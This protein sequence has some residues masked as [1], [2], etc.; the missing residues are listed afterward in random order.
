MRTC[1][2]TTSAPGHVRD[3]VR[4]FDFDFIAQ[5][6]M[7][8]QLELVDSTYSNRYF[9]VYVGGVLITPTLFIAS[10]DTTAQ[11]VRFVSSK[12]NRS[13][14]IEDLGLWPIDTHAA[15][16]P[17]WINEEEADI[18]RTIRFVW[19]VDTDFSVAKG[20]ISLSENGDTQLTDWELSGLSR[21]SNILNKNNQPFTG[22]LY[23]RF[24]KLSTTYYLEIYAANENTYTSGN[25]VAYGTSTGNPGTITLAEVNS[26][27]VSGQVDY[28]WA[29]D[30]DDYLEVSWPESYQI[31]YSTSAMTF[32]RTPQDTVAFNGRSQFYYTTPTIAAG[33]YEAAVVPVINGVAQDTGITPTTGIVILDIPDAPTITG[34]S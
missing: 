17:S 5:N 27:G 23:Y 19:E 33:T 28:N 16:Y 12:A 20:N 14:A 7:R 13:I 34:V 9:G 15:N 24:Y 8:V 21:W 26:S 25:M 32:P 6:S 11:A 29:A 18:S 4:A 1:G 30:S 22:S 3:F 2:Q 10:G 31:H